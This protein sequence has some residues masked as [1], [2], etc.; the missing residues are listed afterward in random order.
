V[1]PAD[2]SLPQTGS[3][4][5][6][7]RDD[8]PHASSLL[9]S[10]TFTSVQGEGKL[11]GMPSF[12]I[13]LSGCNLR[14]RWCDTPYAS[15]SPEGDAATI[16]SLIEAA[17]ASGVGHVVLTGGEPMLFE[18]AG[19][20]CRRLSQATPRVGSSRGFHITIETA[21]T[22][23]R[24]WHCDLFSISPKLADST[25]LEGDPRDPSGAWR[26]RHEERRIN[27]PALQHLLDRPG[28]HQLKFVVS[29][30]ADLAEIESLLAKLRGW[31]PGDVM[32]MPEGVKSPSPASTEWVVREC[33]AR[34]WRYCHRLHIELFGNTRGT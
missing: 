18:A 2:H 29:N 7:E 13:R 30:P 20:L 19:E 10:E 28:D 15:W 21:G 31:T 9:I 12:F 33:V 23:A 4:V 14:C 34:G 5:Q 3:L 16:D 22:I 25:P 32:L 17:I 26:A 11:T 27:L 6:H 1:K 8:A 24:D